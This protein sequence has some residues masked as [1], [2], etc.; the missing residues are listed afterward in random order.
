M[1]TISAN[2]K[3]VKR[4]IALNKRLYLLNLLV[5]II[6]VVAGAILVLAGQMDETVYTSLEVSIVDIITSDYSGISL[7]FSGIV[8][9]I[10]PITIIF[11]MFLT[12]YTSF[13]GYVYY[14]YQSLLLGGSVASLVTSSGVAGLINA[15]FVVL[16]I[17]LLNFFLISS[18]LIV[19]YKRLKLARLQKLTIIHST[20]IFLP[21]IIA[22]TVGVVFSAI[23]YGFIYPL[24]IRSMIIVNV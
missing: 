17:N 14:A 12:R 15:L 18:S 22:I 21:K 13:L 4:F 3:G 20:K 9:L 23:I 8:R 7:F 19:F 24:L 6:G 1:L 10:I 2:I 16:P 5:F 11:V